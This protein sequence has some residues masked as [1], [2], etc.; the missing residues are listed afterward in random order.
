MW[1]WG[2]WAQ[3]AVP[4][5]L[6]ALW[7][8]PTWA[9]VQSLGITP[10]VDEP[11]RLLSQVNQLYR[12]GNFATAIQIAERYAQVIEANHSSGSPEYALP[13]SLHRPVIA[14]FEK[15]LGSDH[16]SLTTAKV[17][18]LRDIVAYKIPHPRASKR[19]TWEMLDK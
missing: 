9:Q 3:L 11:A 15:S 7:P 16:P 12:A 17:T 8:N 13:L 1:G 10:G 2:S 5:L 14:I 6:L 4:A 18:L 19:N